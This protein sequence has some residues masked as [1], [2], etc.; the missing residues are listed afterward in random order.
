LF[1]AVVT[2]KLKNKTIGTSLRLLTKGKSY[3]Q[4][5]FMYQEISKLM[6]LSEVLV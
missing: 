3:K 4:S 1:G 5:V 6:V 2:T